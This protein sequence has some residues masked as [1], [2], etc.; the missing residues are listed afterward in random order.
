MLKMKTIFKQ[1]QQQ[2]VLRFV[3]PKIHN[4][5]NEVEYKSIT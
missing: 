1:I 3:V 4:N 2:K 5:G